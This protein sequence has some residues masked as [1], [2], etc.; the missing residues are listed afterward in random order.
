MVIKPQNR[1]RAAAGGRE[2]ITYDRLASARLLLCS[3]ETPLSC[4]QHS[5]YARSANSLL[6]N[7]LP[8]EQLPKCP[9]LFIGFQQV[10][11]EVSAILASRSD[12]SE[13]GARE[14]ALS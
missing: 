7:L 5:P 6:V 3:P 11:W 9:K 8:S 12:R 14:V 13:G 10:S 1:K 2:H 4:P